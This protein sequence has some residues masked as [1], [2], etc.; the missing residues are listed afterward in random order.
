MKKAI[1]PSLQLSSSFRLVSLFLFLSFFSCTKEIEVTLPGIEIKPVVNCLFSPQKPF[2]ANVSL[3][4][5]P[6]D[7][8]FISV[9]NA[10]VTISGSNGANYR[11]SAIGNGDYSNPEAFPI[12]GINYT[13][14]VDVHGYPQASATDHIPLSDTRFLSYSAH[15]ELEASEV[16][17]SGESGQRAFQRINFKL[18]NDMLNA[19]YL[20]ISILKRNYYIKWIRRDSIV[21]LKN[22]VFNYIKSNNPKLGSE[23]LEKYDAPY[24][25]LFKDK[26]LKERTEMFDLKVYCENADTLWMKCY[27]YSP[28]CFEFIRASII[29]DHTKAYD[30]WEVYEPLPLFSNITNGYGIFAG[31]ITQD[32]TITTNTYGELTQ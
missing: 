27:N 9:D 30:F 11:L 16:A 28:S 3:P 32:Y 25:F 20:G 2:Q 24:I 22:Y 21:E 14:T 12:P 6:T 10:E 4:G 13:I 15:E 7:T 1:H 23:G 19:D 5:A 18:Q 26:L 17:G 8:S 31:Y 29:H